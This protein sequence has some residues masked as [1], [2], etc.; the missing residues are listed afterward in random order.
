MGAE[1]WTQKEALS[2]DLELKG[3]GKVGVANGHP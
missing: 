3:S 2:P 1:H